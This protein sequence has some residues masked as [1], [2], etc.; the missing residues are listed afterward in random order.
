MAISDTFNGAKNALVLFYAYLN[1]VGQDIGMERAFALR[2]QDVGDD[3][4]R[5]REDTERTNRH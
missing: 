2:H 4:Y 1:M 5:E 3:W